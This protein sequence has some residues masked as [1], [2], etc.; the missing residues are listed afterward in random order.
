MKKEKFAVWHQRADDGRVEAVFASPVDTMYES[1]LVHADFVAELSMDNVLVEVVSEKDDAVY[2]D[3]SSI[4]TATKT[5][6]AMRERVALLPGVPNDPFDKIYIVAR[7]TPYD[8]IAVSVTNSWK[9]WKNV[10][11]TFEV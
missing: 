10:P 4:A 7:D 11:E 2:V 1:M 3:F 8:G 6:S 5:A 9:T